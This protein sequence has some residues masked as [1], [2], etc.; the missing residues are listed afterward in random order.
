MSYDSLAF[1]MIVVVIFVV[2]GHC[3]PILVG[4]VDDDNKF[5]GFP[6]IPGDSLRF[7]GV[8]ER[9]PSDPS[10]ESAGGPSVPHMAP[11][12]ARG[13]PPY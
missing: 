2:E 11:Q 5:L 1:R 4:V 3:I 9:A 10:F 12:V 13:G 6:R 8:P 7:P